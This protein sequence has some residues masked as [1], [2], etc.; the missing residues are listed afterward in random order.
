MINNLHIRYD[1]LL[2]NELFLTMPTNRILMT[3]TLFT[4]IWKIFKI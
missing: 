3:D 4:I 2:A 1:A